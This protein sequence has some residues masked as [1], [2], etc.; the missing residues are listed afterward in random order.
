MFD[1][2]TEAEAQKT[3]HPFDERNIHPDIAKV[4][5]K[6]FDDGHYA[7]ATFEAFKLIDK[8]VSKISG[9]NDS[10]VSLMMAAFAE[11]EPKIKLTESGHHERKG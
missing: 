1:Q 9:I 3:G 11:T 10:G 6:L 5:L 4:S 7:Q 8:T 2:S